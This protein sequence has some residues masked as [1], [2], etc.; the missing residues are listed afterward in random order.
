MRT[1]SIF[2]HRFL[3][4]QK[5]DWSVAL[6]IL[7][8]QQLRYWRNNTSMV[9][10]DRVTS[11][12]TQTNHL[13]QAPGWQGLLAEAWMHH[14]TDRANKNGHQTNMPKVGSKLSSEKKICKQLWLLHIWIWIFKRFY[15]SD[16]SL[17]HYLLYDAFHSFML[18]KALIHWQ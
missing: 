17:Y 15:H 13:W 1:D 18:K 11:E 14:F 10:S 8:C 5:C 9:I 6:M 3:P 7:E 12:S 2:S 4:L 16:C